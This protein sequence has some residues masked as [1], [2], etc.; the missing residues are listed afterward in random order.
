MAIWQWAKAN[1]IDQGL[2]FE[3]VHDAINN[4]FFGGVAPPEWIND[5]LSGRK[6]PFREVA[7][8]AW[9]AQYRRRII[10]QQARD[11]VSQQA[12]G[13]L[14]HGLERVLSLPRQ[15]A[16]FGHGFVFPVTHAGDLAFRPT[17][18]GTFFKGVIDTYRSL[19]PA[20]SERLLD[21]MKR[22]PLYDTALRSGLD[23]G[24]KSH[25]GNLVMPGKKGS[26]SERA[27]SALT[28]LR[29]NLWDHE[30]QKWV[31]PAMSQADVL[32]I[33]KNLANWANHATGSAKV[34]LPRA[35]SAA[36]FG[37]KLTA[38]KAARMVADP[39]KT[40][41]TF[42]N[43]KTATAGEKAVALTRLSGLTQ[44]TLTGLG[45]LAANQG[46]LQATGQ[47][48]AINFTDPNKGDW[49]KFKGGGLEFGLPGLHSEIRT[50]GQIIATSYATPKQLRGESREAHIGQ[51][52]G[53]YALWKATPAVGIAKEA[54]TGQDFMGRPMPWSA[55]P[56]KGIKQRLD[57]WQYL[58]SH[59]PIPM[60]G[61]AGYV[62]TQL[63]NRGASALDAAGLTKAIIMSAVGATG[64]H[65]GPDYSV[66]PQS[67]HQAVRQQ[68][69]AHAL[70]G[71]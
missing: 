63:K 7:D 10:T 22:Q 69:T 23:V 6:T 50:L 39:L 51:I 56:G 64:M 5:I 55:D 2:P 66:E 68:R 35:M 38:S 41:S 24:E 3:K 52:L 25:A 9:K 71:R 65:V 28:V 47:K 40:V 11:L 53:Q 33:G 45:L 46:F 26:V 48:Q 14:L 31:K 54:L 37:P 32:D 16:V 20:A 12:K 13:P 15:V 18:W 17:S 36:L 44:Y 4:H 61:P 21:T 29:Y 34:E 49:L 67:L 8:A 42:A 1:G 27:W 62:Y 19:S 43:W 70:R 59:A 30:M 58:L 57:S 60:S